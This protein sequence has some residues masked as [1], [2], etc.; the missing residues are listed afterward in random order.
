M[1]GILKM[2]EGGGE[3]IMRERMREEARGEA[4]LKE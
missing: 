2:D 3:K 4:R 1:S